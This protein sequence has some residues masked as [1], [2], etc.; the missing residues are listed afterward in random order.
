MVYASEFSVLVQG[1]MTAAFV[2]EPFVPMPS[3]AM[4][5]FP[6]M[7]T[8]TADLV[9]DA[10]AAEPAF[11]AEAEKR[12]VTKARWLV[13]EGNVAPALAYASNWH[14]L[15]VLESGNRSAWRTPQMTGHV[16]LTCGIPVLVV[17]ESGQHN[18]TLDTVVIAWNGSAEAIRA[19]HASL[20]VLRLARKIV[21][22]QGPR[23]DPFSS[24]NCSPAFRVEEWLAW[25][26]IPFETVPFAADDHRAGDE[27][28]RFA[29][30]ANADLLVMGAYGHTRFSEWVLG[31]ATRQI[32]EH[33]DV[34]VFMQH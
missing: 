28:L 2:A 21:L 30:Q 27:L 14:D 7:Y 6:E 1:A 31:G 20:P 32:L 11:L 13:I 29:T 23:D 3:M 4:P 26:R 15:L 25:R 8:Y 10:R 9:R 5:V 12:G 22:L 16:V 34:P 17:P 24:I 33:A 19:L 18:A